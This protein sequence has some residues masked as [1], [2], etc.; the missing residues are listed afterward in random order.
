MAGN[1]HQISKLGHHRDVIV[2]Y[3]R[4]DHV[5]GAFHD[6]L[7]GMLIWDRDNGQRIQGTLANATGPRLGAARCRLV[8]AFLA[9]EAHGGAPKPEWLLML[10]T[11]MTGEFTLVRDLLGAA[12][13]KQRELGH[14][15]V[16]MGGLC[17]AGGK[18]VIYPTLY[19]FINVTGDDGKISELRSRTVLGYP[20][21]TIV[22]VGGTGAAC[23]LIH[24]SV[25][26]ILGQKVPGP[27]PWYQ[28][29]IIGEHDWG[30][31]LV[32]CLRARSVADAEIYV[33]TGI[34]LGH[35]KMVSLDEQRYVEWVKRA[36]DQAGGLITDVT[37]DELAAICG[38]RL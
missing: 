1:L 17:F 23:T 15:R 26:E 2:G 38:T 34:K 24:R 27:L 16:V 6:W 19:E 14:P 3:C 4:P 32:F 11:D 33:H 31:D 13:D 21:D 35:R 25:L 7:T 8:E 18:T 30:E 22:P 9:L 29:L 37:L 5:D 36:D 10:D 28:D 20:Q 12:M